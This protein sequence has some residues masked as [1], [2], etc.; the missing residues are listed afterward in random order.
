MN[1]K[2][3]IFLLA[4]VPFLVAIAGIE[5]GVRQQATALAQTQHATMQ[6]AYLSSKEVELKH[7]VDLATSAI[8]PLYNASGENARDDAIRRQQAL[9]MLEK[10][11]F[12]QDGYFFV[13][14]M[15]GNS[16]MHPREP[17]LVG[18]NWWSL[19]DPEGSLTIQQLIAAASRGG[20]YVRY[21]WHRPS[22]NRLEAKLGYVVPLPRWGWMIGT[23]IYL[24]DVNTTLAHIDERASA[25]IE[26]TMMWIGAIALAG[27]G[28]IAL[29]AL[30]VN[31]S[32]S[33]SADAKLKQLAQQVVESQENERARLSRE[34]H[35]GISQMM[36]SIKLL[37]ESALARFERASSPGARVPAA[38]AALT[39][40]LARLSDTLREVR[41]I[42]HALRPA[43][44]DDLGLAAALEQ[45]TRE[46]GEE[47]GIEL[48]FT[49]VTHTNAGAL[50]DAVNTALFRIA[51]EALNNIVR[52]AQATRAALSLDVSARAVTLSIADNGRGFDVERAQADARGGIGLRNMRERLETLSGTLSLVSQAGHTVV[53]A[54]VPLPDKAH[55]RA[56]ERIHAHAAERAS[57]NA[58]ATSNEGPRS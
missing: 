35:D 57:P 50:P 37:L 38:E 22:T 13:Y 36:V 27:F 4:I 10:M 9:A 42:S 58:S 34:L 41:R 54:R 52:H 43:M 14:D 44:L 25:N 53:T 12:G 8:A 19:R 28:V 51:Q 20:G 7:Y 49:Q 24:D 2:T 17:N 16:L 48:G 47:T 23:G 55:A 5:F 31:V 11:D 45:L 56:H 6:T 3:K 29:C 26:R 21:V 39:T 40:G 33:R 30:V 32:E 1:L 46:L 15:H 18:H